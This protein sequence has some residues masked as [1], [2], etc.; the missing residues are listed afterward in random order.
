MRTPLL[1]LV[2]FFLS[3]CLW[4]QPATKIYYSPLSNR[5]ETTINSQW[6]FTYVPESDTTL[7]AAE[8]INDKAWQAVSIPQTWSTYE[9][10]GDLHPFIKNPSEKDDTYWWYGTGWYRKKFVIAKS[11]SSKN[12]TLEFDGV[13][14]NCRVFLNGKE[15]GMHLGGFTSFYFD[16]TNLIRFDKENTLVVAVS[17]RRDDKYRV[18]PMTAGNWVLY[19]GIYRDV[20][21]VLKDKLYIPFQGDYNHEGGTF[22]TTPVVSEKMAKVNVRTFVKNAYPKPVKCKLVSVITESDNRILHQLETTATI[23]PDQLFEFKQLSPEIKTPKLWSPE[24]PNIY[25]VYSEVYLNGKLVDT[26]ESPL[27]FRWFSWDKSRQRLI[28]NGKE[29]HIHGTNRHQEYPWLGDA[30]PKW[31][32][33]MDLFDI[34]YNLSHNFIRTCHYSQDKYVYD[35]CDR[36]GL[37]VAEEVPNIKDIDFSEEVQEQHVKEM[38]R[39][40]RN[41]PSIMMWSMGNE[42]ND[43][44]DS[45]WAHNEDTTRIIHARHVKGNSAGDFVMHTDEDMDMEN[46]LRCT[47][48][49]W[50]NSDVKNLEPKNSQWTGTE[51]FQHKMAMVEGGSQRG[52]ISMGNGVMWIYADHGADREYVN[53][54]LKHINPKGWVDLYR[55]PKYLYY[56]WQANYS[57]KLMAFVHPHFWREQYLG[58]KKD[59]IVDSNGDKVELRVNGRSYGTLKSDGTNFHTVTFKDVLVEKGTIEAIAYK[60]NDVV[61]YRLNMA[62]KPSKLIVSSAQGELVSDKSS[63]AIIKADVVDEAGNHIYGANPKLTW[64]V[65]GPATLVGPAVWNTDMDKHEEMEG[66]FYIDLPVCNVIRSTGKNGVVKIKVMAEGLESGEVL[67]NVIN[68]FKNQDIISEPLLSEEGRSKPVRPD[69]RSKT[70]NRLPVILNDTRNDIALSGSLSQQNLKKEVLNKI[71]IENPGIDPS[72]ASVKLL[73]GIF[74]KHLSTNNGLL[75]ADDYN[76]IISKY[77]TAREVESVINSSVFPEAFKRELDDFYWNS[78]LIQGKS[79]SAEQLPK[80]LAS[81]AGYQLVVLEENN[82]LDVK[83]KITAKKDLEEILKEIY[84]DRKMSIKE[85]QAYLEKVQQL[86]PWVES[87]TASESNGIKINRYYTGKGRMIL[88]PAL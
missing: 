42:T 30:I 37:I 84:P 60:N 46:L 15:V 24:N 56:L 62:G 40:D 57:D 36:N 49:G 5:I 23:Q 87:V 12:V 64:K 69:N 27:G 10:T 52:I 48:R 6:T 54:P 33:E 75:V 80:V 71:S 45:R 20:R 39:R 2:M 78:I 88:F 53:S 29:V 44:A 8:G 50:Y 1:I 74:S 43:A 59:F 31:I 3:G 38:I 14:K 73:A 22:V 58:Q 82:N 83:A 66:T 86:N 70:E 25:H 68:K 13:M 77:N 7:Y 26:Y 61:S 9:T 17:N 55:Q 76:F 21:I 79:F 63:V 32:H 28:L 4:A 16:I 41:H 65:E 34:R 67:I 47:V 19:G 85:L 18:P 81:A 72:Q 51:E 11:Q 35:W